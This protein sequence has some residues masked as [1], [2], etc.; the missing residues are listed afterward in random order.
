MSAAN[1]THEK[2]TLPARVEPG[3]GPQ[4][5]C[6]PVT[7]KTERGPRRGFV[8]GLDPSRVAVAFPAS[9]PVRP[10]S[11]PARWLGSGF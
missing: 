3:A 6:R 2:G 8:S 4:K 11:Q 9:S 7:A 10:Q 1:R 5:H